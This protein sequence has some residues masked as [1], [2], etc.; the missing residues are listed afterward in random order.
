MPIQDVPR[1]GRLSGLGRWLELTRNLAVRDVEIR[2][3]HSL[4]GLYWAI[5]NPLAMAGIYSFVFAIIFRA[6]TKPIP[7]VVFLL[8][9]LTFW[10]FFANGLMSAVSSITGNGQLLAKIYFP[11]LVLPIAAILA[12]IIDFI[13]SIGVLIVFI[14]IEH[15][16]LKWTAV[17]IPLIFIEQMF[18]TLGIGY[19][20]AALNVLYRDVSQLLGLILMVWMYLTPVMYK[21][22]GAPPSLQTFLLLNP[23]GTFLNLYQEL[24]FQ[25]KIHHMTNLWVSFSWTAF[26]FM[27]GLAVL[28]RLERLFA[29]V[30]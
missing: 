25:G 20:V 17:Y 2:Y 12:R 27:L 7:Y 9:N 28:R 30:M 16:P 18:F 4:L 22:S 23:M 6:N 10:N 8:T 1:Q 29:E 13:F 5:I 11:R 26:V 21:V 14:L 15:V 19:M 24:L 3:K